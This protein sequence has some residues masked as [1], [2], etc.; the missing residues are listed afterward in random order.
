MRNI[1]III[2]CCYSFSSCFYDRIDL[3]YNEDENK[4]LVITAWITTIDEPHFIEVSKTVNYLGEF[5]PEKI[6]GVEATL[7]DEDQTYTLT[8]KETGKYY[9]PD[10]WT[11]KIGQEY[12]LEVVH[13]GTTHTAKQTMRPCPDFDDVYY[14]EVEDLDNPDEDYYATF[15]SFQEIEGEGDGYYAIDYN[16]QRPEENSIKYGGYTDDSFVDGLY[17][18]DVMISEIYHQIGDTVLV[19]LHSIGKETSDFLDEISNEVYRGTPLD[20]PPSNVSTNF[21]GGAIG[22]FVI[23]DARRVEYVVQ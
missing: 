14:E 6:S 21:E 11:G 2:A 23:A 15:F 12:T 9:L 8:E 1:L 10:D 3:D 7:Q 5:V 13:E 22:Y 19:E 20:P 18:A 4:K 17:V 16:K